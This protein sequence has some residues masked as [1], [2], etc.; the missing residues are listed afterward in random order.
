MSIITDTKRTRGLSLSTVVIAVV[1]VVL[2]V[3]GFLWM[4]RG[5]GEENNG[6]GRP[7]LFTVKRGSFDIT[8]PASGELA[9]LNQTEIR[10]RLESRATITYIVEEGATVRKGDVLIRINDE[11]MSNR[12]K[13]AEDSVNTAENSLITAQSNMDLKKDAHESEMDKARLEVELAEL[14]LSA[15]RDGDDVSQRQKLDLDIETAEINYERLEKRYQDSG[16]LNEQGFISDDEYKRDEISMIEAKARLD[17][18]KLAKEVYVNYQFK[19]DKA[20]YESDVEQAKDELNRLKQRQ[21]TEIGSLQSEVDSR[22]YHFNRRKDRLDE[23]KQQLAYCTI[24]APSDGMVVYATSMESG[25]HRRGG[26]EEP[27]Q[28]G[29]ELRTNEAVIYLPDMSRLIAAVKVN[30]ALSGQIQPG[31]Q[32][33]IISDALPDAILSGEVLNIS[34]LAESGG[35][36]DRDRRDYT[37]RILLSN[38]H[39]LGLKPSMRCKADIHIGRVESTLFIPIQAVFRNGPIAFVYVPQGSSYAQ[40]QITV[41]QASELYVEVLE[42][43]EAG[44]T[45]LLLEP[46]P[47]RIVS[48]LDFSA[49]E[50][51]E[52]PVEPMMPPFG[53]DERMMMPPGGGE[54]QFDPSMGQG[55][56]MGTED[57]RRFRPPSGEG[58]QG[59]EGRRPNFPGR[60]GMGQRGPGGSRQRPNRPGGGEGGGTEGGTQP[61]HPPRDPGSGDAEGGSSNDG[62]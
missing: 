57:M 51:E 10:N 1:A 59:A 35:W 56:G 26:N 15:W 45:V 54:H 4:T 37:V 49:A 52:E 42:G 27:P 12:V 30:E 32:A 19:Q 44:E 28:I 8:V 22:Q 62:S 5:G 38:G 31:Q 6:N 14:A 11:E 34:V 36:F 58:E 46:S 60:Q 25:G 24:T 33:T 43:L 53:D 16:R 2:V 40:R 3:T 41:G 18:A 13:D 23:Y 48:Q 20:R 29:T 61:Q 47:E 17:Q 7:D 50:Q 55:Q 39:D 9:A 21:A